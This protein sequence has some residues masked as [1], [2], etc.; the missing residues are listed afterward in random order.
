M[1]THQLN[2]IEEHRQEPNMAVLLLQSTTTN[3][4]LDQTATDH[5]VSLLQTLLKT[6]RPAS[7]E[8]AYRAW[9]ADPL[10][11]DFA[12][13]VRAQH[14]PDYQDAE[15][16]PTQVEP[17]AELVARANQSSRTW[18]PVLHV[19]GGTERFTLGFGGH[20]AFLQREGSDRWRLTFLGYRSVLFASRQIAERDAPSFALAVLEEIASE[21]QD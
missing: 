19:A 21:I 11:R 14:L 9:R 18:V 17:T 7:L 8:D 4:F 20:P 3:V 2:L 1:N 10:T 5:A 13:A 15:A 16:D 12:E 6:T